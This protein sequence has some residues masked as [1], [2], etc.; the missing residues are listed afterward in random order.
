MQDITYLY[1]IDNDQFVK[2]A[3]DG[4]YWHDIRLEYSSGDLIYKG[5]HI[6]HKAATDSA[7]WFIWKFTWSGTDITRKEGPIIGSWDGRAALSWA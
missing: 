4:T 7:T 2:P 1:D 6:D 5:Y 3:I